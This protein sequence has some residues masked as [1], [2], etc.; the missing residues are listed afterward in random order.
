VVAYIKN[1]IRV[2]LLLPVVWSAG[3]SCAAGVAPTSDTTSSSSSVAAS[4]SSGGDNGPC[5][6]D[7][8]AIQ[9]PPCTIAVCNTGQALGALNTCVVVEAPKGT[10]CDDG[11]F[12][13]VNDSCDNGT[14]AGGIPNTCGIASDPCS[15]IICYED[16]KTCDTAPV[17]DGTACTPKA[18]CQVNGVCQTGECIGEPKDCTFSP[19]N[20]CNKVA[21]D[22]T[23]G[24]CVGTPDP[25]KDDAPCLLTGGL[26]SASKTCKTGQCGGGVPK[27]CSAFNVGCTIGVC[28][29]TNGFCGPTPAPVGAACTEGISECHVGSCDQK[30]LCHSSAGPS[31]AACNDH[32]ACTKAD[33]CAAGTCT[34]SAVAGCSVYLQESFEVCP[35]GWT[36]GGDWQ[37]G[38]PTNVGPLS[39]H[40]GDNVIATQ[41]AGVYSINQAYATTV[42]NSPSIDLTTAT[43]PMLSFWAWDHTE[44]GSF[45][46]WNLKVS[47]NGGQT[48]VPVTTVIPAY[49]LNVAAQPA[50]G[51]DHSAEGWKNYTADLTAFIGQPVILRFAFRSDGAGVFPGVYIDD[52]VV[53]EPLQNPLFITTPSP[54]A[55]IY[56]D[57]AYSAKIDK[58]G[59]TSSPFWKIVPGGF[60]NS[61]LT[62][63]PVKGVLMGTPSQ[64]QL[65][66]VSVVV[67]VEE[68][69]LPS[70]FAEKTF[71]F[72]VNP[73]VYYTS[74]ESC[75]NGW[76]LTGD[77]Q[78][79]VPMNVG[80]ATAYVGAQCL[81]TQIAATYNNLQTWAGATATSPDINLGN[82]ASTTLTFRMWIDT[83]GSTYDGA[84][85]LI[86][87]DGG[88]N[89]TILA[90]VMPTYPLTVA[91]K[92]A[93]GGHQSALGWQAVSADLSP[94]A[95]QVIRLQ[96]AFQT[97]SSGIYPGVYIDDVLVN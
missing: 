74:F 3:C 15:A 65:G 7:C 21:C 46:G 90:N 87:T 33:T 6:I 42:A 61:W 48:F 79:G 73:A 75:P 41:I 29:D 94:Y 63:D 85:L 64:A 92:P 57:M 56:A 4:S 31:G 16:T 25:D 13:T 44:G 71:T 43:N 11:K 81:A 38:P 47:T 60:N 82:V 58:T 18:L 39:A 26:C 49:S 22:P 35:G 53:A 95:G 37:C 55:D 28:D 52:V 5:G 59:G 19:L 97:D 78:C 12:C 14:C 83:E 84:N 8:S 91:G 20:E 23:S 32:N 54:L 80:P 34:G 62:I 76:T 86:S 10:S 69:A 96:F 36:F 72:N 30:G 88:V 27:D 70:N 24:Q 66:P 2:W 93:W 17:N 77:W 51:G 67:H 45:D 50:W 1:F 89:Y 68:S 40:T 9:T